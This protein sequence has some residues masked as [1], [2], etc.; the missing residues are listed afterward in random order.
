M[1][2]RLI[3]KL[4]KE[5]INQNLKIYLL[6]MKKKIKEYLMK[7]Q[8][9]VKISIVNLIQTIKMNIKRAKKKLNGMMIIM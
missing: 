9:I 8:N 2:G 1:K 7:N 3:M 5:R 4:K 6:I